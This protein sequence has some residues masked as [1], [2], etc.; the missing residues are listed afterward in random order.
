MFTGIFVL[1]LYAAIS[2]FQLYL[3]NVIYNE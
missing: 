3:Q 1:D 2:Q